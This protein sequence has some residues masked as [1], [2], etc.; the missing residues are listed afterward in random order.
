M[1]VGRS[2]ET[3]VV[4][5]GHVVRISVDDQDAPASLQVTLH[6]D[7]QRLRSFEKVGWRVPRYGV[8]DGTFYCWS[9]RRIVSVAVGATNEIEQVDTDEDIIVAFRRPSG[10]LLICETSV[11]LV[12][13]GHEVARLEYD[14]VLVDA[15]VEDEELVVTD[16]SGSAKRVAIASRALSPVG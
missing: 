8:S 1:T 9:A 7:G 10:W 15:F 3:V 14:D 12:H 11:R 2:A 5:A 16:A 4:V 13:D 6:V